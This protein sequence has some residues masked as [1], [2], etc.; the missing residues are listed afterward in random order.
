MYRKATELAP[1]D[2]ETWGSLGDAYRFTEEQRDLA[3]P[4]YRKAIE[5]AE[6]LLVVNPND[7]D[8]LAPLAQYYANVSESGKAREFLAKAVQSAPQKWETYYFAAVA[9]VS[10]GSKNAALSAIEQAVAL[11]YPTDLLTV[12]AGLMP[13]KGDSRFEAL[14]KE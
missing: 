11:G 5:L 9:N 8:T 6:K 13:L 14:L 7:A 10:L 4:A 3:I 1:D 2:H 12:D